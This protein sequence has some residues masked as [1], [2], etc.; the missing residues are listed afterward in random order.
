MP[1]LDPFQAQWEAIAGWDWERIESAVD[2]DGRARVHPVPG[3]RHAPVHAAEVAPEDVWR[4]RPAELA[5]EDVRSEVRQDVPAHAPA[6]LSPD[7]VERELYFAA[8]LHA[9][10]QERGLTMGA[11][12]DPEGTVWICVRQV[13]S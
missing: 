3:Q 7:A 9:H 4:G 13:G 12:Q 6:P 5:P 2:R 1:R 10:C 11:E 8:A